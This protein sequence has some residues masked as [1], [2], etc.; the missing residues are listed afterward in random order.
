MVVRL[1]PGPTLWL[2]CRS[3]APPNDSDPTE[4]QRESHRRIM[5]TPTGTAS[6]FLRASNPAGLPSADVPAS[7]MLVS[8]GGAVPTNSRLDG[9]DASTNAKIATAYRR[10]FDTSTYSTPSHTT[11]AHGWMYVE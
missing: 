7:G 3:S 2:S 1:M 4:S 6:S 11:T 5:R 8:P 9:C 10:L